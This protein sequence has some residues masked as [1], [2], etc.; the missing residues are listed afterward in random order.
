MVVRGGWVIKALQAV[1]R[2]LY[3]N[4]SLPCPVERVRHTDRRNGNTDPR[5]ELGV[6]VPATSHTCGPARARGPGGAAGLYRRHRARP[7]RSRRSVSY[8]HLTLP[9]N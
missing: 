1:G 3:V 5:S 7:G 2:R 9:T 6:G 8:T 4:A